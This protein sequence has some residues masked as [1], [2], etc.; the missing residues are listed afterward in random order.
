MKL[1][2]IL[3]IW[4]LL[5]GLMILNGAVREL[6]LVRWLGVAGGAAISAVLGMVIV[7]AVTR[8]F[9]VREPAMTTAPLLRISGWW[10]VLTIGFEFG[11]GRYAGRSWDE[12][13]SAYAFWN[14]SLWPLI[15]ASLV[16]APFIWAP[17]ADDRLV[18]SM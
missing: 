5:A 17:R 16:S 13:V 11:L 2:R 15:L 8:H 4:I 14:G 18:R 3:A 9:L 7:L 1:S 6:A 12:L 10:L